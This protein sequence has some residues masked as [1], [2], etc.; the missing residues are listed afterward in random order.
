MIWPPTE[1]VSLVRTRRSRMASAPWVVPP[2]ALVYSFMTCTSRKRARGPGKGKLM[3]IEKQ[4]FG[5]G[6]RRLAV[7]LLVT[8]AVALGLVPGLGARVAYAESKTLASGTTYNIGD[9][10][11]LNG[12]EYV[13]TDDRSSGYTVVKQATVTVPTPAYDSNN[14]QWV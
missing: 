4:M 2:D 7:S 9:E 1:T 6:L 13:H 3:T 12:N 11:V 8:L 14:G 5:G 10:V